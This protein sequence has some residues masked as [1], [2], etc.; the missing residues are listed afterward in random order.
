M[1]ELCKRF[2]IK[3]SQDL[4]ELEDILH[5]LRKEGILT[6]DEDGRF[7]YTPQK[8]RDRAGKLTGVIRVTRRGVGFVRIGDSG[9]EI[10]ILPKS[11]RTA[12][13][14][15]TVVV[16]PFARRSREH[17]H[18]SRGKL[19]GEVVEVL[20]RANTRL[21]GRLERRGHFF[22]VLPDD[23][24][25]GRDI[26]VTRSEAEKA[27]PGDKVVVELMPWDDE[28]TNPEGRIA[29]VLGP[30]GD[31]RAEVLSVARSFRL[32]T[33]FPPEVV[34]EA[35]SFPPDISARERHGRLDLR[36]KICVTID[37]V[38]AKDFDDAISFERLK[39]GSIRLGVH[40][41]DVSHYVREGSAL[42]AEALKRGTSVYLVNEVIPMLPERLSNDLCSLKPGV[43]RLT[44][45]VLMDLNE[46]GTVE[47]YQLCK[48]IIRSAR[49]FTYEEVQEILDRG[50]GELADILVPLHLLTGVLY[51]KR[52]RKGSLDFE[53]A[54][55]KFT[56][57]STGLP[58]AIIKKQRLEAH[59]LVEECM[60]L[61]N[62]I[63]AKHIGVGRRD[64]HARPFVYRIHDL[65]DPER[66]R[67]LANFVKQF[68]FSLGG[69]N[70]VSSR[71]LQKL[72]DRVKGSEVETLINEV[73]LRSMA[74]AV[75]S[76]K[77]IGH[78]GLA[79]NYY[80]HFTSPIR[81]YPDLVVHRLL[82]E[83]R[84]G[85]SEKRR[86][87]MARTLP[88]VCRQ[89]SER[90]RTAME[91]ERASVK[92]MQVE[93]M[94]RHTGDVFDGIIGGVTEYGLFV[95]I[96]D[97]LVEGLVRVRDMEDD[98]YLF[99]EKQ[100]ALRGRSSGKV[101][102]LGDRVRV[103]VISVDSREHEIDLVIV[104]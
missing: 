103:Q 86:E 54:E 37:P 70:G 104:D 2:K 53:T 16:A 81:R 26:S 27:R 52:R 61:A 32:P 91:A 17:S 4:A 79:F 94:K 59:R 22:V 7:L 66:L 40:I 29:E 35:E 46:T 3:T 34:K 95:E 64:E 71:E 89:A 76:E 39:N 9:E 1:K 45:T 96:E 43:D 92:V 14:G 49:R 8:V 48:S 15:D 20:K 58:S 85:V 25:I 30:S 38:D 51:R 5:A 80:T 18:G 62:K 72:L 101:Y 69:S 11:M 83:Y 50:A 99:D 33:E 68:G 21:V 100:Y 77:N 36:K 6:V 82:E 75:Y 63:V 93:Y 56:F 65:P 12:L 67:D 87:A 98:Y 24:R 74:K 60:L 10:T 97:L 88:S 41:A 23:G 55:A 47:K 42:D 28:H 13:H 31:V 19:E 44:F 102:R 90:E 73:A 57:D 78:Y 84:V